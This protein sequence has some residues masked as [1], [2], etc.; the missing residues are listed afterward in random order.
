MTLLAQYG[1]SHLLSGFCGAL[2][3]VCRVLL[4]FVW[5]PFTDTHLFDSLLF[6]CLV[7]V[8]TI[9]SNHSSIPSYAQ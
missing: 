4:P 5:V 7:K 6:L 9:L 8:A 1:L 2:E 3:F